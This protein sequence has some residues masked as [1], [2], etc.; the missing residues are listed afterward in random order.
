VILEGVN[1]EVKD[2]EV[3]DAEVIDAEKNLD[4]KDWI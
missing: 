4:I 1:A 2:A 3:I